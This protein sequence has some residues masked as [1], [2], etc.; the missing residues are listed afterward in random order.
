MWDEG[1]KRKEKKQTVAAYLQGQDTYTLHKQV[2]RRF[3]RNV[4][5]A[6]TVDACWQVDL[7]DFSSLK[8]DNDD[9]IFV[10]CVNDVFSRFAWTIPLKDKS[11]NTVLD[12]FKTLFA[13]TKRRPAQIITDKGKELQNTTLKRFLKQ[14]D[15]EL[16]HTN[17][18]QTKCSITERFIRTLRLWLQKVFTHREKY[19][20]IDG[21]LDDVTWSY[22]HRYHTAIKMS[23]YEASQ[24]DRVLEV[25]S[26]LYSG[27]LENNK[28][29]SPK[30]HE[31]DY[32]RISREKKRFEKGHTWNWSEEIFKVTK[33]IPH[34]K[35]VY[36]ISE[37][38]SGDELEGSFYSWELSKVTKP[39]L[40]KIAYILGKR[41]KGDRTEHLVHWRGY[42]KSSRSWV[43]AKDIFES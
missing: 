17:N 6:D 11:A 37:I 24:P 5:Y 10:M 9:Y 32:V 20:Y 15:I 7:A 26:N 28:T 4:T 21:L 40:F 43:K 16:Y 41:G 39:E 13:S 1:T 25:Y 12:G 31:G 29:S 30:F 18:P 14:H 38:D 35:I 22:N 42:T 27:K 23:P 2:R 34:P 19:R 3:P 36:K 8:E 33:V